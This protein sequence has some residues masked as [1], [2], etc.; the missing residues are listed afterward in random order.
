[1]LALALAVGDDEL[2]FA[3]GLEDAEHAA[4]AAASSTTA[5]TPDVR[6]LAMRAE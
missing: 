4:H 1:M 2:A 5:T 6:D 3:A